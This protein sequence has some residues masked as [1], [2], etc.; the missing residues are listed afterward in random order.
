LDQATFDINHLQGLSQ[1]QVQSRLAE[2]GFNELPGKEQRSFLHIILE[3]L[4]EPMFLLLIAC[5]GLYLL[6]GDMQEAL[7][8][9]GFVVFIIGITI[10]Q[11]QKTEKALDALRDLSSPRA[12][13]IREGVQQRIAGRDVVRDDIILLSEGDRVP[14]DSILLSAVNLQ[15]DESLLTGESIPVQ[16]KALKSAANLSSDIEEKLYWVYSG[17]MVVKGQAIAQVK[18]IGQ[19]T[20]LGKIGKA[21]QTLKDE[22]TLLQRQT[23]LIVKRFSLIGLVFCAIVIIVYGI[24]HSNWIEGLLAGLTLAMATL[25]EEFPVVLTVFLALGAWRISQQHVLTRR[26][27]AVETLGA[28][29]VL[30]TD[31]TGTLTLNRM[32]VTQLCVDSRFYDIPMQ[33]STLAENLHEVVEYSILASPS[34]PFDPME[35]AIRDLGMRTLQNTEHIHTNWEL[36]REY[37]LSEELLAMS[38]VWKSR[39]GKDYIIAAKGAPEAIA[40]LCHYS[41]QQLQ[42]LEEN[43]DHMAKQGLRVIAVAAA[44]F[45]PAELPPEQHDFD[46]KLIGLLGLADPVRPGVPE[47]VQ[48]CYQA[49]IRVLMVTGDYPAT[50]RSIAQQIGLKPLDIILSGPEIEKLSDKDLQERLKTVSIIARAVPQQ[51]LRIVQALKANGEVVAMTGDG[52]NDAPALK[53]AHIGVAMGGRGTDVARESSD[54]VL[55]DDNFASIVAAVR[56]GRRIYDNLKKAMTYIFSVH[57]PI[58]GMSL[59]P[60][61]FKMPLALLPVHIVFLELIIDPACSIVFEMEQEEKDIMQ[62]KPRRTDEELFDKRMILNGIVQ[63]GGVLAI[64]ALIYIWV[65]LRGYG[66]AEARL[67]SFTSLVLGNLGLI[68]TNRS[69]HQP[70]WAMLKVPNSALWWVSGSAV[71]VLILVNTLPF[72]RQLFHFAPISPLELLTCLSAAIVSILISESLKIPWKRVK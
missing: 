10:Y 40:D 16:K 35:K 37:P 31:K 17:T 60:V 4:R 70:I 30:C 51:K 13:V 42:E 27:A 64:T 56:M 54:L 7:M 49:G 61:L 1:S 18:S 53:A 26:M 68:F 36:L 71:A 28:A 46:F 11:E 6:L 57:I 32:N 59:L 58:V 8:L 62:R 15:V 3:V 66:V 9:L 45:R 5:G 22:D 41:A 14:A 34:D 44:T 69:T 25:P 2:D 47:A 33:Q 63:G 52:V 38:R 23:G 20:E 12:L 39:D 19:Q 50:A 43:I 65:L 72:L 55:L 67:M 21:L 29:T 48:E 24:T